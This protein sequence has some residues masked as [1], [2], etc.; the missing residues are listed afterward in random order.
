M[1]TLFSIL[2]APRTLLLSSSEDGDCLLTPCSFRSATFALRAADTLIFRDPPDRPLHPTAHPS[3]LSDLLVRASLLNTTLDGGG[4]LVDG[5]YL[6]G[7]AMLELTSCDFFSWLLFHSV[8]F[9][10][11]S[12][13]IA[14]RRRGW[15]SAPYIV[16]RD[17]NF[18]DSRGDLFALN[19]G[20]VLFENC[21]FHNVSGRAVRARGGCRIDFA[22]CTFDGCS[23]LLISDSSCALRNCVFAN[24][25][26]VAQRSTLFADGCLFTGCGAV[27][28]RDAPARY[29]C[30]IAHSHFSAE[31]C[32]AVYGRRAALQLSGNCFAGADSVSARGSRIAH[33]NTTYS[34]DCAAI[35]VPATPFDATPVDT[36]RLSAA[37]AAG[38]GTTVVLGAEL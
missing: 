16:F 2:A 3:A 30:E 26:V 36:L 10:H 1:F 18:S 37:P 14:V 9:R 19:G 21:L 25:S 15:S 31:G 20:A 13:P 32:A 23:S 28:V 22:N 33:H 17:C 34:T 24:S 8:A 12:K 11:F 29:E 35:S 6:A 5:T 7:D 38:A 27:D 4:L